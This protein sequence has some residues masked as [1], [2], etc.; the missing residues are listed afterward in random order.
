MEK[1][2]YLK[3]VTNDVRDYISDEIDFKDFDSL[4]DLREYLNYELWCNGYATGNG[5]GSY[6]FNTYVAE[7]NLCHNWDLIAEVCNEFGDEAIKNGPEWCDVI[8][9]C[10]LLRQAIKKVLQEIED[11]FNEVHKE[12]EDD[13]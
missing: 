13:E 6:T 10:Y 7:E 9:R 8:I 11:D 4:D 2:D 12:D 3:A 1:Y 5:V